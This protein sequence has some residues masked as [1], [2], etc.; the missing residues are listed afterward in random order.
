LAVSF[1]RAPPL[2]PS[3]YLLS[4]YLLSRYLIS[5]YLISRYRCSIVIVSPRFFD[6]S[7]ILSDAAKISKS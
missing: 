1:L 3:R 6:S 5:R 7:V 2:L 4:R